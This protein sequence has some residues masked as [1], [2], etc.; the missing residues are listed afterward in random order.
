MFN[1]GKATSGAPICSG[2][3]QLAKP[4]NSGIAK[5]SSITEPCMVKAWLNCSLE[6]ICVPGRASS[7]RMTR[8][9]TPPIRKNPN[10]DTRYM[11]PIVL[12]SVVVSSRTR[13]EPDRS[14]RLPP[15]RTAD[16]GGALSPCASMALKDGLLR[17]F[18]GWV[19][20]HD[21]N[22]PPLRPRAVGP[23]GRGPV[24]L[25]SGPPGGT[26][27]RS[28]PPTGNAWNTGNAE[29]PVRPGEST[30]PRTHRPHLSHRSRFRTPRRS[31][32]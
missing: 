10:E 23:S 9:R 20:I 30:L 16:G 31:P 4:V 18:C 8:A 15:G 13:A 7:A 24:G 14:A 22:S 12:W 32:R 28:G 6:R 17:N 3:I 19:A 21:R 2:M 27:V 29:R 25:G 5:S 1:R 11:V 26:T